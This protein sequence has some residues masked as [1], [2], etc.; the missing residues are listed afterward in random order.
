MKFCYIDESGTAEEPYAVMVGI[1]VDAQRMHVT[2]KDW[3]DLLSVLSDVIGQPIQE[4]HTR[5]FYSGNGRW[6]ALPG[7]A[8]A[9]TI[10]AIFQWLRDRRHRIVY[11]A[12]DKGR[13]LEGFHQELFFEDIQTLWRFM[14][15]HICLSVQKYCQGF[16]KNKGHTVFVFDNQEREAANFL[17]LLKNPPSWTDTYYGKGENQQP[18]DQVVDVPYFGDSRHVGLLQLADFVSYFIRR[19]I[20][21]REKAIPPRYADED[22]R[23]TGWAEAALELSVAKPAIYLSRGRCQ[24]AD[25]FYRY[26]PACVR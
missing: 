6:R 8:R 7:P 26:A 13:F 2:K 17:E 4:I 15:L 18:L 20:E 11:C 5:D 16:E 3:S 14:A 23:V 24:C 1:I 19:H 12:V 21:I 22:I 9:E 25:L 10:E